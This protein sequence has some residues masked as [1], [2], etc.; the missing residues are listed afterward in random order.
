MKCPI[1]CVTYE[2]NFFPT[3]DCHVGPYSASSRFFVY[4]AISFSW[5]YICNASR[6]TL[7]AVS[8]MSRG[9][10]TF[11]IMARSLPLEAAT[12]TPRVWGGIGIPV[13]MP[14]ETLGSPERS[15]AATLATDVGRGGA[16]TRGST[17]VGVKA[18]YTPV[19]V[20]AGT[21]AEDGTGEGAGLR[22]EVSALGR[23]VVLRAE[24]AGGAAVRC[25]D[26]VGGGSGA[27]WAIVEDARLLVAA[28]S[29]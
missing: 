3:I 26:A 15:G 6:A 16:D 12:P 25:P 10:S 24:L 29:P 13:G 22:G 14:P 28:R 4:A 20:L 8:R 1:S 18:V 9:I 5:E 7:I 21:G 17:G 2:P 23:G 27:V 19:A 11:L